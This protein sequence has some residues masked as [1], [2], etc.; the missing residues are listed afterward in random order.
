MKRNIA[1]QSLVTMLV[2][3]NV[4]TTGGLCKPRVV[5]N[6]TEASSTSMNNDNQ[7]D[8]DTS[9]TAELKEFPSGK[10]SPQ[11]V[12]LSATV[13]LDKTQSYQQGGI[14]ILIT[15]TNKGENGVSI[16][17][18]LE[19]MAIFLLDKDGRGI[20]LPPTISRNQIDPGFDGH[21]YATKIQ[22]PFHLFLM[23]LNG[24]QLD[25]KEINGYAFDLAPKDT[26]QIGVEIDKIVRKS[27]SPDA[28]Q[29]DIIRI[30][31]GDYQV[32]SILYLHDLKDVTVQKNLVSE[33]IK[34]RLVDGKAT[35]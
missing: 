30:P 34:V 17:T 13:K 32:K 4:I 9:F 6:N 16:K 18:P 10:S 3:A 33:F 7:K 22:L 20:K 15:L 11:F 8:N 31:T 14:K 25:S 28:E 23:A 24:R 35:K 26:I 29:P 12:G 19:H 2:I 1:V 21:E 5:Q 27:S